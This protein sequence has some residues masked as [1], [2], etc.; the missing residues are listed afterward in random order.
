MTTPILNHEAQL[1]DL[2]SVVYEK[3]EK[4]EKDRFDQVNL[5]ASLIALADL[6][7]ERQLTLCQA[8]AEQLLGK[9]PEP[10]DSSLG[11]Q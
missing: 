5:A 1:R 7:H 9:I 11:E 3:P 8:I 10:D 4:V 2:P 6:G